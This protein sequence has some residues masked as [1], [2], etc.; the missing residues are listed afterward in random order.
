MSI[1]YVMNRLR[2]PGWAGHVVLFRQSSQSWC[3]GHWKSSNSSVGMCLLHPGHG[4]RR[5]A[6]D[7]G[8][9]GGTLEFLSGF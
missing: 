1:F 8:T 4:G 5:G 3:A 6:V 9:G 7:E 2:V